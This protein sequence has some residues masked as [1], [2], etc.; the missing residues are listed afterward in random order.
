[1]PIMHRGAATA[2]NQYLKR[3]YFVEVNQINERKKNDEALW[4]GRGGWGGVGGGGRREIAERLHTWEWCKWIARSFARDLWL[5]SGD[6]PVVFVAH[7]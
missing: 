2:D 6:F 5:D 3:T 4:L 1:M 7:L